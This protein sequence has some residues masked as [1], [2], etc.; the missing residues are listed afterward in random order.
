MAKIL[1]ASSDVFVENFKKKKTGYFLEQFQSPIKRKFEYLEK[2]GVFQFFQKL[3][4]PSNIRSPQS[5]IAYA[6]K[7]AS[8]SSIVCD[9]SF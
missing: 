8:Q 3:V 2:N 9:E 5:S 1:N 7:I 6:T 4:C